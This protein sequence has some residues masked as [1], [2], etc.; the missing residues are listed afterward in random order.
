MTSRSNPKEFAVFDPA[1]GGEIGTVPDMTATQVENAIEAAGRAFPVWSSLAADER[2]A[3]LREGARLMLERIDDLAPIVTRENGKPLRESQSEVRN[4]AS[5]LQWHAEEARRVYGRIVPALASDRRLFVLKQPVGVVAAITPW[6][7]PLSMAARKIAPAIAAGCTIVLR[8]ASATPLSA[9]A[10]MDVL[11]DAGVPDGVVQVVTTSDSRPIGELFATSPTVRKITFTGSTE[12]GKKLLAMAASG[13]KN[14]SMELGGHCPFIVFEDADLEA[15]AAGVISSKFLN[16]GQCC[17]SINRLY[18]QRPIAKQLAQEIAR[19]AARLR[20]G[21]GLEEGV[22]VGPLIDERACQKVEAHFNDAVDRGAN[23]LTG[24][25]RATVD[26]SLHGS[27]Y[28][29]TILSDVAPDALVLREETF[30]PLLPILAFDTEDEAI[31]AANDTRFG[32]EACFYTRDLDRALRVGE[33]LEYGIVGCN[34][35]LPGGAQLPFGGFKESG[36]GRENGSEGIEAY[37][38]TKSLSVRML[39]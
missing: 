34:D 29:P 23:V 28:E 32:L 18:A 1:T 19:R 10:F 4:S 39:S 21:Y 8:P 37:L 16:G 35:P 33:R 6:N 17:I 20:V 13:V 9:I 36:L 31:R 25:R 24:G 3:Y 22:D 2:A 14:V 30:G 11:R 5:Y 7:F 15:A 38:E 26:D 12:V 27:F